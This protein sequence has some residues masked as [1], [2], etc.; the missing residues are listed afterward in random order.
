[1][2]PASEDYFAL[3]PIPDFRKLLP[4]A[5]ASDQ[6]GVATIDAEL[7][8]RFVNETL[9]LE[10]GVSRQA[11][12]GKTVRQ[13]L[14]KRADAVEPL[15][16]EAFAGGKCLSLQVTAK[17]RVRSTMAKWLIRFAPMPAPDFGA[18][19]LYAFVFEITNLI[20]PDQLDQFFFNLAGKLS[21]LNAMVSQNG[22]LTKNG[23][24]VWKRVLQ[25]S[26]GE[27]VQTL[28]SLR[29]G[30][31]AASQVSPPPPAPDSNAVSRLS[32]RQQEILRLLA[33]NKTNKQIAAAL[34]ISERTAVVHRQHVMEK[35]GL[36]S[37]GELI[38]F[39]I[40]HHLVEVQ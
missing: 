3:E 33:S 7:R 17:S 23:Q 6:I 15:L 34:N 25:E 12:I 28:S 31:P 2:K 10:N 38:H 14:G 24:A 20:I 40:R 27:V 29:D 30:T 39:A 32:R 22:A 36:H 13:I 9:A 26:A 35:L 18:P 11:H 16:R 4:I 21:Y 1:V 19:L 8:Y 5:L 37:L